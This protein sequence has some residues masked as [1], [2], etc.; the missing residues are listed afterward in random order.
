ME[1]GVSY[2]ATHL[3]SHIAADMKHLQEIGCTEVLFALQENHLHTLTGALRFGAGLA[4]DSGL[5]PY[6]VVW[7]F[8]N[9]FGGGRMSDLLLK[10]RG[11]WRV[12]ADGTPLPLACL[13]NP[14]L[15]DAFVEIAETCRGHGFEGM[16]VDEPQIQECF[17]GHCQTQFEEAFGQDLAQSRDTKVYPV[18]QE[19]TVKEYVSRVCRRIKAVDGRFKT[20]ACVMPMAPH[21]E[22]FEPVASIPELDVFGTD[23]YWLLGE[24]FGFGMT[25]D[26]ACDYAE[27]VKTLCEAKGKASQVWLNCWSIPA[28]L[29]ADIYTGGKRLA[30]V[31]C[32]SLYTWSFRGGL[33]T[34]EECDDPGAA[35]NSVVKLYRE[36][37][38][39]R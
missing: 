3:P 27:R 38:Q 17:C 20:M 21:D 19:N 4:K 6:V 31:G 10:D 25:V 16:F 15:A 18:F 29:E 39:C 1:L 7:G 32:D 11:L 35:W 34:N 22:L 8:A 36:L 9:T 28:G 23:P 12:R 30:E 2:I 26:D 24:R 13:N 5:K 37:S 14:K 33:G